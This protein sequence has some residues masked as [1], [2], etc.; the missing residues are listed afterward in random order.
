[1]T[2]GERRSVRRFDNERYVARQKEQMRRYLKI[3]FIFVLAGPPLGILTLWLSLPLEPVFHAVSVPFQRV[4]ESAS[5]CEPDRRGFFSASDLERWFRFLPTVLVLVW[6]S[7]IGGVLQ[8]ALT[9]I[10]AAWMDKRR[11]H[12]PVLTV[13]LFGV[14]LAL[15]IM[16]LLGLSNSSSGTPRTDFPC[17]GFFIVF[18]QTT[19]VHFIPA[20]TCSLIVKKFFAA[21]NRSAER[22]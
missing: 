3:L 16:G 12:V 4:L 5:D 14:A 11:G 1:M 17:G 10:F 20:L 2:S 6:I 13:S 9:G 8:A 21:E 18:A 7:Y 22:S 15:A 19:L